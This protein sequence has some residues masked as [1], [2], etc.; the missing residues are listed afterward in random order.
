MVR[1]ETLLLTVPEI[2][3]DEARSIE[4]QIERLV[5]K[6]KGTLLSF[7]KW[8]KY[9]LCYPIKKND[10][11]VYY[12]AR[13]EAEES[14][15]LVELIKT[16]F[17]VTL[18]EVVMRSMLSRLDAQGPLVYNRPQSLEETPAKEVGAFFKEGRSDDFL[19][20]DRRKP[21]RP[22]DK[23]RGSDDDSLDEFETRE[24]A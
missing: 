8:G 6:N 11:G 12:L 13:F 19:S 3:A 2:T 23:R 9:R 14:Q 15:P 17:A 10:Y 21:R 1:Y 24:E 4:D 7:E 5:A 18:H 22:F 20:D 16:L